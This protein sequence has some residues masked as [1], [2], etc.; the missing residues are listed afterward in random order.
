MFAKDSGK[1]EKTPLLLHPPCS[2]VLVC[3]DT[4]RFVRDGMMCTF[5]S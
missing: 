5:A 4:A 2:P 3:L 1:E